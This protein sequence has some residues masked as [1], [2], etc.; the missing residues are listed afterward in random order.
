MSFSTLPHVAVFGAAFDPPHLGH[1]DVVRQLA[2]HVDRVLLVPSFRHAFGKVMSPWDARWQMTELLC[3]D[4][5]SAFNN[6]AVCDI[7]STMLIPNPD[8]PIY[9]YDV[10]CA[11]RDQLGMH[12]LLVLGP[13]NAR[14]DVWQRFYRHA[15]IEREFGGCRVEERLGI[16]STHIRALVAAAKDSR[17]ML[18]EL[19]SRVG[20]AV[21][22]YIV[23]HGLYKTQR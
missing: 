10:L 16:R 17:V 23:Q 9:S 8:A 12:P 19:A 1:A 14:P 13:D 20:G 21:A 15:D 2:P 22:N 18:P 6:V 5:L 11:V 7:E 4:V 3:R